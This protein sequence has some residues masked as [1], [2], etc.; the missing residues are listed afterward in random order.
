MKR[1]AIAKCFRPHIHLCYSCL[2][3]IERPIWKIGTEQ[4]ERIA[5]LH[6]GV[7]GCKADQA[8]HSYVV[9][10]VVF[11][12]FLAAEGMYD[13]GL[14]FAGEFD[15][16]CMRACAP[17]A[18]EQGY[19]GCLIEKGCQMPDIG[20]A[21]P[22]DGRSGRYPFRNIVI[23]LHQ[24]DVAGQHNNCNTSLGDRD[25]D[26]AF[27]YLRKLLGI[28][29][30]LDIMAAIPEQIFRMCRLEIIDSDFATGDVGGDC[31]NRY[32][33][34]LAVEQAVDQMKV[35]GTA[36]A[37]A[38]RKAAGKMSFSSRCKC[39][40]LFMTHVD[41]FDRLS[42]PQRVGKAIERVANH[43]VDTLHA[44]FFESFDQILG[45]NFAHQLFS[46]IAGTSP[47][48]RVSAGRGTAETLSAKP[49]TWRFA[50]AARAIFDQSRTM[51]LENLE[52]ANRVGQ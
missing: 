19:P 28:G 30:Q 44:R 26:C 39:S 15:D 12:K 25:P 24:R 49:G 40:G 16:L 6:G 29:D 47:R 3:R 48:P 36:A 31:Q 10:V 38:H 1:A 22:Q 5:I 41:P 2:L 18:A 45:C 4:Q 42:S 51:V 23:D 37:G 21:W 7:A 33:I 52:I 43:S 9:G 17:G 20:L 27:Q 46:P 32:A 34:A 14:Q 50:V 13:R 11:D 35:A 8:G